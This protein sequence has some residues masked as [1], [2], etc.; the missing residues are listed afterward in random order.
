M[1]ILGIIGVALG[2][3]ADSFAVALCQGFSSGRKQTGHALA[4][5]SVFALCQAVTP[6]VGWFLGLQFEQYVTA[7]DHWIAFFLLV[8]LGG[9]MIY[10]A[11]HE[12]DSCDAAEVQTS[13]ARLFIL[14]FATSVD[15]LAVGI[16]FSLYPGFPIWRS[17]V[18]FLLVTFVLSTL[19]VLI[20]R[21]CGSFLKRK[22]GV[23]GGSIL[24]LL[25]IKLLLEH[26]GIL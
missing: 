25:G 19:G 10:D 18:I 23:V 6:L 24:I 22:A 1:S 5:G 12:S 17:T 7:Y 11:L 26:L 20:G 14:G 8:F 2:L 13:V 21:S 9:R 4:V 3:S 15:A 16:V